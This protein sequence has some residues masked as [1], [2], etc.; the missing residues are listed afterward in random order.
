MPDTAAGKPQLQLLI[1][2]KLLI[3][4]KSFVTDQIELVKSLESLKKPVATSV[5][6]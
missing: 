2:S 4:L 1:V 3:C 6:H 5:F